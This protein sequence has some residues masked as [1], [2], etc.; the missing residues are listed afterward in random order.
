MAVEWQLSHVECESRADG[1]CTVSDMYG[2]DLPSL[3][4]RNAPKEHS[5]KNVREMQKGEATESRSSLISVALGVKVMIFENRSGVG[6]FTSNVG[7]DYT[8]IEVI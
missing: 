8:L 2:Y 6:M 3:K 1:E 7:D 4:D 5:C